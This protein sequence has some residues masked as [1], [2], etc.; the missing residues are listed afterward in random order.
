MSVAAP[1]LV[2]DLRPCRQQRR[3]T[4]CELAVLIDGGVVW[5]VFG[6]DGVRLEIQIDDLLAYLTE[7]WKPLILGQ[8]YPIDVSPSK[9]SQL[10]QDAERRWEALLD[11]TV[12]AEEEAVSNFEEAHDLAQAFAGIYGLPSFWLFRSGD[13][14]VVETADRLWRLPFAAVRD[15]LSKAGDWIGERLVQNNRERWDAAI[16][17]WHARDSGDAKNL[18]AWSAG[19]APELAQNLI[20]EK[21]LDAPRGFE[22]AANDDDELRIAAR[23]AG[24]LPSEQ[25]RRI[26]TLARQFGHHDAEP[27]RKLSEACRKHIGEG[28]ESARSFVQGEA[29]ARFTRERL[30]I[31][32]G[33]PVDVFGIAETLR[34]DIRHTGQEPAALEGLAIWGERF[35][36]GVFLNESSTRIL[37]RDTSDIQQSLGARVTLAHELCHLL[38]DGAHAL[39][40]LEILKARM[41]PGVEQRAKSFAGE[42]LLPTRIADQHWRDA[43]KPTDRAALDTLVGDLV[44]G[45]QITRS[46]AAWKLQHAARGHDVDLEVI[47]DSVAPRR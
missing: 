34:I 42:F 21:I 35:G 12:A 2:L 17:A 46:V 31:A 44:N 45:Y 13:R 15:A 24:A 33:Q 4:T 39:S 23:M 5:P 14:F 29:A 19:L 8:V 37:G 38:L 18:L 40:A 11:E 47:L 10:R 36:P 6:E 9:P 22:D 27:L 28:F 3:V 20:R 1:R 30:G 32:D 43:G 25:I 26:I 7:F 16:D 41:P